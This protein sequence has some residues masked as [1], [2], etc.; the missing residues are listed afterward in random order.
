MVLARK[1]K[2]LKEDLKNWNYHVFGNVNVKQQQ[3]FCDLGALDSKESLGGLSSSERDLRGTLLME[4]DKLAHF[5]ETLWRQK[6]RVL[7]LKEGDNNTIF[8]HKIANSNRRRNFMEKL[9][10]DGTLYSS[11]SDIREKVVQFYTSLYTEKEAWRPFVDDLPFSMI[12]DLERNML[13]NR[14]DRDEIL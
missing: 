8:F 11:E 10:V 14:F 12:G 7:W 3:L 2:A 6:S 13:I 5:K 9:E 4:L 1:L